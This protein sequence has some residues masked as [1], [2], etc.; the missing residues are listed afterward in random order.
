M[1]GPTTLALGLALGSALLLQ[2]VLGRDG[3][4]VGF[5][6]SVAVSGALPVLSLAT[7]DC[8]LVFEAG[9]D[10]VAGQLVGDVLP[11]D[12]VVPTVGGRVRRP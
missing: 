11:D 4:R 10:V 12:D 5:G 3:G 8:S 9:G 6:L 2:L 1:G 7:G